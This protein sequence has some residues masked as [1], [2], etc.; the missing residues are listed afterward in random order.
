MRFPVG[1]EVVQM[2]VSLLK[3]FHIID[4]TGRSVLFVYFAEVFV[5]YVDPISPETSK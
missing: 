4:S 5:S 3:F 1:K 2:P